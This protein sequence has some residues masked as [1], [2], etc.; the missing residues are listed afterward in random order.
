[1]S[2]YVLRPYRL[3]GRGRGAPRK[4]DREGVENANFLGGKSCGAFL[5]TGVF[6]AENYLAK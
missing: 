6:S 3:W 5:A 2:A 1:M 4:P